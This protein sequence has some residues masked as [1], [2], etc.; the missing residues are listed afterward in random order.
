LVKKGVNALPF[1]YIFE[2]KKKLMELTFSNC[3]IKTG[4]GTNYA[5]ENCCCSFN[6]QF[7]N[8][9]ENPSGFVVPVEITDFSFGWQNSQFSINNFF[10]TVGGNPVSFPYTLGANEVLDVVIEFCA[11]DA[12][13]TDNWVFELLLNGTDVQ[14]ESG[15]FESIDLSNIATPLA[16]NFGTILVNSTETVEVQITNPSICCDIFNISTDCPDVIIDPERPQELCTNNISTIYLSWSPTTL[17]SISCNLTISNDCSG[18]ELIIPVSGNAVDTLPVSTTPQKN[19]VDQTTRVEACSPRTVNNRCTTART[20]QSAIRT[21]AR[22][23]GK[24]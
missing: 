16:V 19:K 10:I 3:F 4:E 17:G 24:R 23:F 13:N 5:F 15:D 22:R 20:M 7:T 9:Q 8:N 1:F 14:I 12:G 2:T 21:T 6:C 18:L 11:N